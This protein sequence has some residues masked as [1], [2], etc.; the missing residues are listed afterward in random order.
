MR[1]RKIAELSPQSAVITLLERDAWQNMSFGI[2]HLPEKWRG[3]DSNPRPPHC[4][5]G[6]L[7]LSYPPSDNIYR[8][9]YADAQVLYAFERCA[10]M[11]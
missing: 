10:G 8:V 2:V 7:P 11:I 9:C 4:E 1:S 3:W 6:A 5:R